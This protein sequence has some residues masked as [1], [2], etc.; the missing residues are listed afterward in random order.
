MVYIAL[1][2]VIGIVLLQTTDLIPL[3]S[4]GG[5]M[6]IAA[7][8]LVAA[9]AV[10]I[11][12]AWTRKRGMLGWT[13]NAVVALI[14]AFIAV[15]LG[16]PII[17]L[18]FSDGSRSLAAGGGARFSAALACGMLVALLGSWGAIWI[19]NRWRRA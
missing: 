4:V 16:G 10:G 9:L 1:V 14:G 12:E 5:S 18:L 15:P 8:Y 11:H 17:A 7:A 13:V 3:A 2:S 19:V 6:A